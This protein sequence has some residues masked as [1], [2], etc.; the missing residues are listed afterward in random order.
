MA[1]DT[2]QLTQSVAEVYAVAL[3]ELADTASAVDDVRE[4]MDDL[5]E[6][7]RSNPG[8]RKLLE[9]R[10]LSATERR[11]SL[12]RIF[13]GNVSDLLYRFIQV[14]NAKD[15]LGELLGIAVAY[16]KFVDVRHG[17][18]EVDAYVA[19][20]LDDAQAQRVTSELGQALGGT[21]VL[22]QFVDPSL[23]GGIKLRI[24]DKLIDASVATQL[25][26]MKEQ[27]VAAGREGARSDAAKFLEE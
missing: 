1:Q 13:E 2:Q 5:A 7:I 12:Q 3:F 15:R 22:H 11:D 6:L 27:I 10:V 9:S 4:Q 14:V 21:I 20:H 19:A 24:G 17:L 8:L 25:R 16:G 23:I 18:I 26:K